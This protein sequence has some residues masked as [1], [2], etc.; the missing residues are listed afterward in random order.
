MACHLRCAMRLFVALG[1]PTR[2]S[3]TSSVS[4]KIIGTSQIQVEFPALVISPPTP[5][6]SAWFPTFL[7]KTPSK[8]PDLI[9]LPHRQQFRDRQAKEVPQPCRIRIPTPA[10]LTAPRLLH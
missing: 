3:E 6:S 8:R 2:R 7:A 1:Q 5:T 10:N 4:M 9:L